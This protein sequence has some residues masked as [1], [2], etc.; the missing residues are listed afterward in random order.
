MD[1]VK[2][3]LE[4]SRQREPLLDPGGSPSPFGDGTEVHISAKDLGESG[5]R[6]FLALLV[7]TL[8]LGGLQI[9]WTIQQGSLA[10]HLLSLPSLTATLIS[11]IY[12]AGPITGIFVQPLIGFL[13]HTAKQDRTLILLLLGS[14]LTALSLLPLSFLPATPSLPPLVPA[15]LIW[16][17]DIAL[18]IVE[19]SGRILLVTSVSKA[20][21]T[22]AAALAA[23]TVGACKVLG[24]GVAAIKGLG[25]GLG[26]KKF[27]GLAV[28]GS[29]ALGACCVAATAARGRGATDGSKYSSRVTRNGL[30]VGNGINTGWFRNLKGGLTGLSPLTKDVCLVQIWAWMGWFP[31]LFYGSTYVGLLYIRP[32]LLAPSLT[33]PEVEAIHAEGTRLGSVA[34]F[35]FALSALF[36]S[37]LLPFFVKPIHATTS[38]VSPLQSRIHNLTRKAQFFPLSLAWQ[39]SHLLTALGYF[40]TF[41]ITTPNCGIV[42]AGVFGVSWSLTAWA[43]YAILGVEIQR[44]ETCRGAFEEPS[45]PTSVREESVMT[46]SSRTGR[47]SQDLKDSKKFESRAGVILGLHNVAMSAPQAVATLLAGAVFAGFA[48]PNGRGG[49][50]QGL[51]WVMRGAGVVVFIAFLWA[52]RVVRGVRALEENGPSDA[53]GGESSEEDRRAVDD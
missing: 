26:L 25:L 10:P 34:M 13:T 35:V 42:L 16:S 33:H 18:N 38:S 19:I 1:P 43:P 14:L 46:P 48:K 32:R 23:R 24:F 41:I 21:Q 30:K 3:T 17:L 49:E 22:R 52:R 7:L 29:L 5:H 44:L 51:Q 8:P 39:L 37:I 2:N 20:Q 27:Q 11:I 40:S 28:V 36:C 53:S 12:L 4:S 47:G 45:F 50:D 6:S 31:F 15:L 9:A